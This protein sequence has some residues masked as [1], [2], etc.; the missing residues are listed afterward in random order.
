MQEAKVSVKTVALTYAVRPS[1]CCGQRIEQGQA[2]GLVDEELVAWD[3]SLSNAL[4]KSLS[5]LNI[6][7]AETITIY[8]GE[9]VSA[10]AR[11]PIESILRQQAP[12][13][14]VEIVE[15]GQ[16]HYPFIISIE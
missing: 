7:K 10:V 9:G 11:L 8:S 5:F 2:I 12:N 4:A 14:Q 3:D 6:A 16:P 15:G 13:A 1:E